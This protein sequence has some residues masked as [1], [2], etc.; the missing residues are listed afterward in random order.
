MTPTF[1]GFAS[2]S[3]VRE[4]RIAEA[5]ARQHGVVT[6]RQLREAG[7]TSAAIGRRLRAGRLR[8]LHRG[9]YLAVPFP[10]PHTAEMAA[11]L[12]CGPGAVLSH[13][14]A[15]ALWGLHAASIG[16]VDVT[17]VGN[18]GD[19]PGIRAH[20]VDRLAQGDRTV[21][22]GV[23]ITTPGRTLVD[24]AGVLATREL[25]QAVAH[26]ER[27]GLVE[28]ETLR[29]SMARR[30]GHRGTRALRAL[31]GA[32]GGP[33]LTRSAAEAKLLALVREAGLPAPECNVSVGRYEIDFLWRAAGLA[34]EVDGF[35][36]H[37]SRLHF[38]SD[39]RK[40]ADLVA[41]GLTVV[42][43][44]WRQVTQEAMATAVRLGQALAHSGQY[45]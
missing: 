30:G 20:R 10:L 44:S 39:R 11:V 12:A 27:A 31:L 36:Y 34:V 41:A 40:D 3:R 6:H 22:E 26:A 38:E 28:R 18:R 25:E 9:V 17:V 29:T 33:A 42:R 14:S 32:P 37:G 43:L 13:V 4:E 15:A 23:P 5:A 2:V 19:R 24:L 8:V 7:F 21:R 1:A 45:R 35:R 16:P